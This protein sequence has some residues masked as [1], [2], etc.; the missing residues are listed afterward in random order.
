MTE[1]VLI[2]DENIYS[3][4][5]TVD[6]SSSGSNTLNV[7]VNFDSSNPMGATGQGMV[8]MS[9][10]FAYNYYDVSPSFN[11]QTKDD[12]IAAGIPYKNVATTLY[13]NNKKNAI[14]ELP[15]DSTQ[16]SL[17]LDNP[18]NYGAIIILQDTI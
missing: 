13:P 17:S 1:P 14:V 12:V 11:P 10:I 3:T 4:K 6:A 2:I 16:G 7:V 18:Y 5:I 15:T 9:T 8:L